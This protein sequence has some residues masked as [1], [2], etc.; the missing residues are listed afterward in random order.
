MQLSYGKHWFVKLYK[1]YK[2]MKKK[3]RNPIYLPKS[4]IKKILLTMKLALIIFLLS[5]LQVSANV[6]SQ[7]YVNL[8]VQHKSVRE[9]LKTIEQQSQ[10]RFFYSDDLMSMDELIDVKAD[11]KNII[12]VLD[13]IFSKSQ[14]TFK[15]YDNNL[16][17]IAP[18]ELLQQNKISGTVTD[19]NG[20]PIPGANVVVT[21]TIQ[22]T[23]TDIDGKYNLEVPKGA[24]SL[25]F[26][27]IGMEPQEIP[28]GTLTRINVTMVQTAIGLEEVVVVGYG[29]QKKTDLTGS[30]STISSKDYEKQA[31]VDVTSAL[32]GRTTGVSITNNSGA[33]GGF[34]K[35]RIRG[36]NS[37]AGGNDP[38]YVIDGM[39]LGSIGLG[40]I[41][42]NDIESMEILK[43]ASAT[44]IYGSR[45]ANGVI[46][47]TTKKGNNEKTK[48]DFT[49]N[50]GVSQIEHKYNLLD[51]V[52]YAE[53]CNLVT[54]NTYSSDYI[55]SLHAG[56]GTNW[57]D[58]IFRTAKTQDYQVS[59]SG[60][61]KKSK[62]YISG[63][64]LDQ[65]GVVI[66]SD[67]KKYS[68]STNIETELSEKFTISGNVMLS[69][70][71]GF[72]NQNQGG[73]N[74]PIQQAILWGPAEP[75]FNA[76]GTYHLYDDHGALGKN[77]VAVL[78]HAYQNSI[79]NTALINTKLSYK[80]F[81]FLT[82][83]VLAGLDANLAGTDIVTSTFSPYGGDGSNRATGTAMNMQNSNILTFHKVFGAVH[84]LTL[85]GVYEQS[86][87]YYDGFHTG[88]GLLY[89]DLQ[90]Y[91]LQSNIGITAGSDY[92]MSSLQSW[93]GR[94]NYTLMDKYLFTATY[95][96]DGSS[97]YPNNPWGYFPSFALGWRASE[98]D[99]IKDLNLFS[100]L[101]F[102][103]SWGVTGNQAISPFATI[104]K[105]VA[106]NYGYGQPTTNVLFYDV[107]NHLADPNLKW[108]STN[109]IDLGVDLGF[110]KNRLTIAIDYFNKKTKNLLM[111]EP[112][113]YYQGGI[114]IGSSNIGYI[115][116]NIG[117]VENNGIE[118]MIT[119]VP[120]DTKDITWN[121]NLNFSSDN[122]KV[123][124]LGNEKFVDVGVGDIVGS[125]INLSR[126][127]VGQPLGTFYGY[128]FL[129]IYQE[130]ETADA[131]LY[132]L[133]PGDSKYLDVNGDHKIT[134]DDQVVIGHALPKYAW[135][136]DN[137]FRYKNFEFDMFIQSVH[138]NG[139]IDLDYAAAASGVGGNA[140]NI[141]SADVI[142]WTTDN[143]SNMWPQLGSTTNKEYS[144]S[145]K[146][147]QD[148]SYIRV[149]NLSIGYRIP[150]KIIKGAPIKVMFSA[151]NLVT[152][153]KYKGFDPEASS[154][155][156]DIAPGIVMGAY[157]SSR[158]YKFTFQFSF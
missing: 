85:T 121:V 92:S 109:Q 123:T 72:N 103:G 45:G 130:S 107:D 7:I 108:E 126:L 151:Q 139:V 39:Q 86:K 52:S 77:P 3:L 140:R 102:R 105:M 37:F 21:G 145:S 74:Q 53:Q 15:A 156:S 82:L 55:A 46:M 27:F 118:F 84:D 122:N 148:G 19:K 120:I 146:W 79:S 137:T 136:I 56:G 5:V 142:S 25:T 132:G 91:N 68:F 129:G 141:T 17:V 48:I 11:N 43:D 47:V 155:N 60:G 70:S 98:E 71:V 87:G 134:S 99:F 80:I 124:D 42:I 133:H 113:P 135:G 18:R 83:D 114:T 49:A 1:H 31:V 93:V 152:F 104:P 106:G 81:S 13:D 20:V 54:P 117:G 101:K 12:S 119:G 97:K 4:G 59:V 116:R 16:I 157:P 23:T 89:P 158:S 65:T 150:D 90:Y 40:D 66:N 75:V 154:S 94:A 138:G 24:R 112:I 88:G 41:S 2:T 110:L 51:P 76:D 50:L 96:A 111:N 127:I 30:I 67:F 57:Q 6:Y 32:Q 125:G 29:T 28:I 147:I 33:P 36:S 73:L 64:Y 149:K 128:K 44:A 34:T 9:V 153:T 14:L 143:K 26:S 38:L 100:N 35:I 131:A 58:A 78:N 61:T 62:Y 95:R 144:N 63:R 69:R 115:T 22:G 10:V 8:D